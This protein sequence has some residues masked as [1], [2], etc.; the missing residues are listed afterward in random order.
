VYNVHA[1]ADYDK[2]AWDADQAAKNDL[3]RATRLESLNDLR[4]RL[5]RLDKNPAL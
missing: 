2:T 4:A 5:H 3:D 1:A